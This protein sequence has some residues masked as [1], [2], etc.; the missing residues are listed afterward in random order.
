[1]KV[2]YFCAE[3]A[4]EDTLPS[5]AGGLGVLAGDLLL[6]AADQDLDF[7]LISLLYGGVTTGL[8]FL[9]EVPGPF[10]P[11]K[12]WTKKFNTANIF[13][14]DAGDITRVL[15]GPDPLTMLKQQITLG[16][17]GLTLC[18]QADVYHL[19]EGHTAMVI[20]ALAC[21]YADSHPGISLEAA[22][23]A[24]KSK[25]V[26]TKHT[27]LPGAGLHIPWDLPKAFLG[28]ILEK[29]GFKFEEL[30]PLSPHRGKPEL[31]STTQLLLSFSARSSA[32]SV[33]HAKFEKEIHPDSPLI[34]ITNGVYQKRWGNH[35]LQEQLK[36]DLGVDPKALLIVWARRLAA[37]KRPH[38]LF[39]DPTRLE[40][41]VNIP[42]KPVQIIIAGEAHTPN[43]ESE[44]VS[45]EIMEKVKEP[46]IA[47]KVIFKTGYN[48]ELAAK[49]SGAAD[50]WLNT[51]LP[52]KEA[53]GTS[54]MKAGLNHALQ[55]S[56]ADG[57]IAENDWTDLGWILFE[58]NIAANLYNTIEKEIVPL[59]F[60]QPE[61]WQDR[62]ARTRQLVQSKYLTSRVLADYQKKLYSR[63]PM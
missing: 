41:I 58:D 31:F 24:V 29:H 9:K 42:N 51:P 32:V 53:S 52:G 34:P 10:G 36:K 55:F 17:V 33:A 4:L 37:Y 35:R 57:W 19:N 15:Y 49:L 12:V 8:T 50:I 6:E 62:A 23:N 2:G 16:F 30:I 21:E 7:N 5:F 14:L 27:I 1:M 56:T 38:L 54:G 59:F 61:V 26:A 3:Y 13:L 22:L 40:Q 43:P 63:G 20:L 25:I 48:L 46:N 44:L 47:S 39:S 60:D 45:R 18:P 11:V 28:P